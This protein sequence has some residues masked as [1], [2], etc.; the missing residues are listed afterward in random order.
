[1][2]PLWDWVLDAYA[3]PGVPE[4]C[5]KLQD[6]HAQNVS[7]LLWAIRTRPLG[8]AVLDRA[9]A[10]A[11]SWDETTLHPLRAVRRRLKTP[12]P[13]VDDT[14]RE[15]L[16]AEVKAAELHAER[17]LLQTLERLGDGAPGHGSA[18]EAATAA[19]RA[20]GRP[21]PVE[22]LAALTDAVA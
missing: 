16:R 5:L 21:A 10:A 11:R 20:W 12:C 3:R 4:T 1:L 7:L 15:G 18:L 14:A 22:T 13:P 8:G 2:T 17:V 19:A 9:A 6:E